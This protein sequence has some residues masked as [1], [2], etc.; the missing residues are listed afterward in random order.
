MS[1]N[2]ALYLEASLQRY[3]VWGVSGKKKVLPCRLIWSSPL[4][5]LATPPLGPP[6]EVSWDP[7]GKI[8]PLEGFLSAAGEVLTG[9]TREV[10]SLGEEGTGGG[11]ELV[12]TPGKPPWP[13]GWGSALT[14]WGSDVGLCVAIGDRRSAKG[15][16][17]MGRDP[18]T[19]TFMSSVRMMHE[20]SLHV[21][22]LGVEGGGEGAKG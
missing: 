9:A 1:F 15:V 14:D 22:I 18:Q 20:S 8:S 21:T 10:G 4:F 19:L 17:M 6:G 3:V 12:S 5:V 13:S 7:V 2:M 16:L 11:W